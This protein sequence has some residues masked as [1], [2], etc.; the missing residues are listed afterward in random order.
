MAIL[1][2]AAACCVAIKNH[3]TAMK[4]H[5][6]ASKAPHRGKP[7]PLS[8]KKLGVPACADT[9]RNI[10]R[11]IVPRFTLA[12]YPPDTKMNPCYWG[13]TILSA[14][15]FSS[16]LRKLAASARAAGRSW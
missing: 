3:R 4:D 11:K 7:S 8:P 15:R 14:S 9:P 10:E 5:R 1:G 6:T 13:Y 2:R 12:R 16:T